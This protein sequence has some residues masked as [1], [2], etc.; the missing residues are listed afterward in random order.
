MM[1]RNHIVANT[2]SALVLWSVP[3]IC[4]ASTFGPV[5]AVSEI[6][7][8]GWKYFLGDCSPIHLFICVVLF[9]LGTL[10][11]DIDNDAS[12]LG[13]YVH[14]PVGHRTWMHSIY[15]VV[16]F[17]VLSVWF[18]PFAWLAAGYF[19]HLFWDSLSAMGVCW[20]YPFPGYL[21]YG[22]ARVKRGHWLK[23]YKSGDVS[24]TIWTVCSVVVAICFIVL[25]FVV[26]PSGIF[27]NFVV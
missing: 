24:E 11:P 17:A 27:G 7:G 22:K 3:V 1:G 4:A 15:P 13:R 5:V 18:K 12:T 26:N 6:M 25:A 23:M 10:L 20:F 9:Y 16:L 2:A 8:A 14:V 21:D 19:G